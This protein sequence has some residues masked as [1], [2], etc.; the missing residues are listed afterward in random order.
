MVL[1]SFSAR[2]VVGGRRVG[3]VPLIIHSPRAIAA[4]K[5]PATVL[6]SGRR[7]VQQ[8][9][10]MRAEARREL[11]ILTTL[12][13]GQPVTQ[14]ALAERLDI[15]LG[16]SNLYLKRLARKGLIKVTS[17]PRRRL[18]YLVTPRGVAHKTRLTYEYLRYSLELYG[19]A[20]RALRGA[21]AGLTR[22]GVRRVAL[23]GTGEA[24]ELAYLTLRE[25][26]L[27]PSGIFDTRSGGSFLGLPVRRLETLLHEPYDRV[28]V[29]TFED[30]GPALAALDRLGVPRR[31][32]IALREPPPVPGPRGG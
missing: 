24:A 14:R 5:A 17:I 11:E 18:K 20:R 32:V 30:P 9:N 27:E 28:I 12:V 25:L 23:Y 2:R 1:R 8:L 22:D 7:R 6:D 29:A 13:E 4:R 3:G 16:L 15:A 10:A 19:Q 21:L 31:V 26:G